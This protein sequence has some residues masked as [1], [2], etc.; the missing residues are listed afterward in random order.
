MRK[1]YIIHIITAHIF[2]VK[3][4][5]GVER[6]PTADGAVLDQFRKLRLSAIITW[7]TVKW[8]HI[9]H[10]INRKRNVLDM[11][12]MLIYCAADCIRYIR[13]IVYTI[14]EKGGNASFAICYGD[15]EEM[16]CQRKCESMHLSKGL[17]DRR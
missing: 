8:Y 2:A 6:K 1:V 14:R 16:I 9:M 15:D 12:R 11:H 5:C 10:A 17:I 7:P 3:T 4:G 13:A